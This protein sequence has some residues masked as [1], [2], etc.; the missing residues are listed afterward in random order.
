[1]LVENPSAYLTFPADHHERDRNFS[2]PSA[3]RTG[4]GLLLDVNNIYVTAAN[5]R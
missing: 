5:H 4:C 1:M 2:M 3:A